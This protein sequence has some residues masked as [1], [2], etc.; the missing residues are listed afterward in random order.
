[1]N[2]GLWL[3]FQGVIV[4][5]SLVYKHY[6]LQSPLQTFYVSVYDVI[7][8]ATTRAT[9]SKFLCKFNYYSFFDCF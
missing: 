5:F 9:V 8:E 7:T 4:C 6:I 2:H 3:L 1:M